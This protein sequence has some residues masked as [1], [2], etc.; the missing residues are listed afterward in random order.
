MLILLH[1]MVLADIGRAETLMVERGVAR[2]Q[3]IIADQ[4]TR[5][6]KVAANELQ[7][8]VERISGAKLPIGTTVNP[9]YPV[10]VYVGRSAHTDKLGIRDDDLIEGGYRM[11]S[12]DGWLTLIGRDDDYVIAGPWPRNPTDKAELAQ[13]HAQWDEQSGGT[14][15]LPTTSVSRS[16][17]PLLDLWEADERGSLNAVYRFVSDLGVR[18]YYPGELGLIVPERKSIALP[19]V[20]VTARPDF[21]L[22]HLF[23]YFNEFFTAR[24]GLE[25]MLDKVRWQ[26]W[27]GLRSKRLVIGHSTGHGTMSVI[28]RPEVKAAHPEYYQLQS[29]KRLTHH[30]GYGAPC[31]SSQGLLEE[32]I[33]YVRA[34]YDVLNQPAASVA[35]SDGYTPCHCDLCKGKDTP[36]RGYSGSLSDYVW[37]YTDAVAREVYKTH[38]NRKVTCIAYVPYLLVPEKIDTFSPN[39]IVGLCDWRSLNY[40]PKHREHYLGLRRDWL[41]KLPS[42]T[43]WIWDYYLHG[44]PR[45]GGGAWLAAPAFFPRLI[46]EDLR[47]LKGI[48]LGDYIEVYS[49]HSSDKFDA[50]IVN[51]LNCYVTA[52]LLWDADTD[53]DAMLEEYY[54]KFYGPAASQMK[55]FIEYAEANWM[56]TSKDPQVIDRLFELIAPARQAAGDGT[57]G[58]RV[59]RLEHYIQRL[60]PLRER[61]IKGRD[62]APEVRTLGRDGRAATIDGKLDEPFWQGLVEYGLSNIETGA[63]PNWGTTFRTAWAGDSLYVGIICRDNDTS[64]LNITT[65]EPGNMGVWNGDNIEILLETQVH[66][67]Y[68]IAINPAGVMVDVD[69]KSGINTLWQSRAE[70]ACH[71][72]DGYWSVELRIPA[73]GLEAGQVDPGTSVAGTRPTQTYPWYINVCRQRSR[74]NGKELS[75]FSPT[76]RPNFHD[77]MKFGRL[78]VP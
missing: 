46:A 10:K 69:R 6:Q 66:A 23:I 3:I 34:V 64:K 45:G 76:G 47:S 20:D 65:R 62:D 1:V 56:H 11:V 19:T 67:Y 70:V 21:P 4:P 40:D 43:L 53:L 22:R 31:L 75:A 25:D 2:A 17:S 38:P 51:H 5:S 24:P 32:N 37:A 33:R 29:G 26:L 58:E 63:P 61:L 27:L 14:W 74:P 13:V 68:Q 9:D 42:K 44:W 72:G 71:I 30:D 59:G 15:G 52:R 8:F 57:Y 55:A 77:P 48:S 16:Y 39:L 35:P 28:S 36:A 18:W 54:E 7:T 41:A 50:M 12:G 73:A 49:S 60:K 78:W